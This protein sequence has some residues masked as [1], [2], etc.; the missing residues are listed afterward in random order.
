[1]KLKSESVFRGEKIKSLLKPRLFKYLGRLTFSLAILVYL[2]SKIKLQE[3]A[4]ILNELKWEYILLSIF[5]FLG[6]ILLKTIKWRM[7][8]R[9]KQI[10]V[11]L[12]HL[13]KIYYVSSFIG[14]F[15]PSSLGIDLLRTYSLAKKIKNTGESISTVFMDRL[16]GILSLVF[17]VLLGVV[18]IKTN[19]ARSTF[20]LI[21]IIAV[22]LILL[23]GFLLLFRPLLKWIEKILVKMNLHGPG[24]KKLAVVLHA[25]YES[26]VG[27]KNYKADM[28]KVFGVSI[29][30]Q[31]TRISI[32]YVLALALGI[33]LSIEYWVAIVPL[34][35]LASM[36][37]FAVG[38]LGVREGAFVWFL[39]QVGIATST[40]FFLSILA[41]ILGILISL[42]GLFF[43]L[44][45]GI[46][47]KEE[48]VV[49]GVVEQI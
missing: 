24:L 9:L 22:L 33:Q 3:F 17:V 30:F 38:G 28:L 20:K 8:L 48:K 45:S 16:L 13:L 18:L 1:M 35:T 49:S 43:Y 7:L 41:F 2:L 39:S 25:S 36:L 31:F 26:I 29:L 46:A 27:F 47:D 19:F 32:T 44:K 34:V 14:I 12:L 37:P 4:D 5:P 15:L 23:F 42:P 40:A 11:T 10:N 21:A 6:E